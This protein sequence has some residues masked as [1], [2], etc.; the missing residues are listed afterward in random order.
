M[1]LS[2][3]FGSGSTVQA[4]S[5][6]VN[7]LTMEEA[8]ELNEQEK[9]KIFVDIYTDW[10]GWCK[11]MDKATFQQPHIAAYLNE[12][13]YPVK[14]NAEY[15]EEIVYK[16]K[17]HKFVGTGRRGYHS[18]AA[19]LTRG[20]LSYPT[21]VFIAE[22]LSILQPIPGFQDPLTFEVIMTFFA[23]DHFTDTPWQKYKDEYQPINGGNETPVTPSG[24]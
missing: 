15:K 7:W 20:R 21:V 6:K 19:D 2:F 13:Y 12:N 18:L 4:Q 23:G 24:K 9:R 11:R 5:E 10:C 14:F 1:I 22:D 8:L 3:A 16:D 17:V